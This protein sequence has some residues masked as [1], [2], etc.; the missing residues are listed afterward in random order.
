MKSSIGDKKGFKRRTTAA[1]QNAYTGK[2]E[3]PEEVYTSKSGILA[4]ID[5]IDIDDIDGEIYD[6]DFKIIK[7][8][9]KKSGSG[10]RVDIKYELSLTYSG[11]PHY[12][13]LNGVNIV[14][15]WETVTDD[16]KRINRQE[17]SMNLYMKEEGGSWK[18]VYVTYNMSYP[19]NEE[20]AGEIS[21]TQEVS[22][23]E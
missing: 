14:S 18:V 21:D 8:K 13:D 22:A 4:E 19:E 12:V 20:L 16:K 15:P 23:D 7:F 11:T 10:A 1:I 17:G 5:G 3:I 9:A 6:A 2:G